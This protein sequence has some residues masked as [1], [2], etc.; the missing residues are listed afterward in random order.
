MTDGATIRTEEESAMQGKAKTTV[1]RR[2][3]LRVLGA[4][5]TAA[6]A[7][8]LATQAKA[9]TENNDEKRK[10]RYKETEHVKTFY[11]VNRYPS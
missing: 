3:F 5:A 11:R 9:D 2:E 8:P 7:T 6:A 10:A 4:G 1:G